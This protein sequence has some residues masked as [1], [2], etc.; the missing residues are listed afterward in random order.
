MLYICVRVIGVGISV[1]HLAGCA[2]PAMTTVLSGR[3]DEVIIST[4]PSN[5]TIYDGAGKPLAITPAKLT[6]ARK[7]QPALHLRKDG[8]QDTTILLKRRLNR[9]VPISFIPAM[10]IGGLSFQGS[11]DG[12]YFL[13]W[14]VFASATNLIWSH[15]PDYFLGGAWDHKRQLDVSMEKEEAD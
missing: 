7:D 10:V 9:L 12:K 13:P 3:Y 5:V 6:I 1:A 15:L 2:I 14:F 4:T 8:Y 11:P